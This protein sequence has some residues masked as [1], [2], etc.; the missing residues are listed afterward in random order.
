MQPLIPY[1]AQPALSLGPLTIHAF[2]IVVATSVLVGLS[3]GK[4]RFE[5]LGL[6]ATFGERMAWWI[7]GGGF[8]G[9]HLFALLLYFPS[10]IARDPWSLLRVWEDISSF[11]GIVG[12]AIALL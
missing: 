9:A 12:A 6:D 4:R 10:K 1:F 5:Q 7:L 8:L 3:L 11:G 2:G